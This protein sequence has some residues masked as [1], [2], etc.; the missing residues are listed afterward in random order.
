M[1]GN[2]MKDEEGTYRNKR[3]EGGKER[4]GL[5]TEGRP[6]PVRAVRGDV[7]LGIGRV[8]MDRLVTGH[9]WVKSGLQRLR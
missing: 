3:N 5:D 9:C 2:M 6:K 4:E 1:W 7:L 8:H